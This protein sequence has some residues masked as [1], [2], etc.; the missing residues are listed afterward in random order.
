LGCHLH[1]NSTEP[2]CTRY[3]A[4]VVDLFSRRVVGWSMST[5]MTAQLLTDALVMAVWRRGKP[6]ALLHHSDR[7]SQYTSEQFQRLMADHG[8]VCS[9]S[10]S[11]NVWDNA[12]V[13]VFFSRRR[14][15]VQHASYIDPR[16]SESV[17]VRLRRTLLQSKTPAF[18]DRISEPYG[19]RTEGRISLSA[20]QRNR[21]QAKAMSHGSQAQLRSAVSLVLSC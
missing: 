18:D 11:G 4:A 7:G 2:A 19:V 3:V 20:C 10:R 8:V 15:N 16:R 5:A 14:P 17:C 1:W 13:E 12:A 6:D 9:M 21:V